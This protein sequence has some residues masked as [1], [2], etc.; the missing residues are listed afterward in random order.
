MHLMRL[1]RSMSL[2]HAPPG[3]TMT[4]LEMPAGDTAPMT[5]TPDTFLKLHHAGRGFVMPNTRHI[6]STEGM[7]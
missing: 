1:R 6:A 2:T 7:E 3:D 4:R 5:T